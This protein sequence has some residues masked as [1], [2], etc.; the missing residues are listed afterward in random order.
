MKTFQPMPAALLAMAFLTLQTA[1]AGAQSVGGSIEF[2][3]TDQVS[4]SATTGET[5]PATGLSDTATDAQT[6]NSNFHRKTTYSGYHDDATGTW[7]GTQPGALVER[8]ARPGDSEQYAGASD[9]FR[10]AN[11]EG[12]SGG[13]PGVSRAGISIDNGFWG[14]DGTSMTNTSGTATSHWS[15]SVTF[16]GHQGFGYARVVIQLDGSIGTGTDM[17]SRNIAS[18]DYAFAA[19]AFTPDANYGP[20]G[21]LTQS[22]SLTSSWSTMGG[23]AATEYFAHDTCGAYWYYAPVGSCAGDFSTVLEGDILFQYGSPITFGARLTASATGEAWA[24]ATDTARVVLISVPA[25]TTFS[26]AS[27][28]AGNPLNIAAVPEP[29][30][31][32]MLAAGL[33][34]I[35]VMRQR[36]RHPR[37]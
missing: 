3:G 2:R 12:T 11:Y 22:M 18:V 31:Y 17:T 7:L 10:E 19:T 36:S 6:L 14:A 16:G 26:Y 35:G 9:R 24:D 34:L 4:H 1:P 37:C 21:P 15:D 23:A 13:S 30:T 27:A 32:A 20:Y 5:D 25:G 8:N 29:G 33:G 28:V